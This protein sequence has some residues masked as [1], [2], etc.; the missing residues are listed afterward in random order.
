MRKSRRVVNLERLPDWPVPAGTS[1]RSLI[2]DALKGLLSGDTAM[3]AETGATV[4]AFEQ[5]VN[6]ATGPPGM[7]APT[8]N[9]DPRPLAEAILG[10]W[11]NPM[12]RVSFVPDGT[13]TA[14]MPGGRRH[15]ARWAAGA[16]GT[17]HTDIWGREVVSAAWVAGDQLTLSREE[18]TLIFNRQ[19]EE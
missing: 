3:L 9:L 4:K 15:V 11:S 19:P 13:A 6:E 2:R 7:R 1:P 8:E 12:L 10:T 5:S 16:D 14:A 17:L 18:K